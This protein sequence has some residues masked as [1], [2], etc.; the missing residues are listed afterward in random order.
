M[1]DRLLDLILQSIGFLIPFAVIDHFEEAV[2]LRLGKHHRNLGPGFHW[3]WPFQIERVIADNVVPR[4]VNLGSQSLTT[5][6]GKAIVVSGVVTA[7][8]R[9]I[10]KATLEV[11][12][13]D[14]AL[15]D[16]CYGV[17]GALVAAHSWEVVRQ[18]D[19][20][21]VLTRACRKGGWRYG[22]EIE[23]VQLSDLT[24]SRSLALHVTNNL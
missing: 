22:L 1:F 10:R 17:I 4:T 9:D 6:D 20:S 11:E 15:R 12:S 18:E 21:D 2:V 7:S 14:H 3:V 5:L 23:K 8:I 19:F 24:H 16:S 13:V